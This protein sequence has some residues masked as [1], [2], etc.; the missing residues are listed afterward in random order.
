MAADRFCYVIVK[1]CRF[2]TAERAGGF[3]VAGS[4][5]GAGLEDQALAL[6][7][8][9]RSG[10]THQLLPKLAAYVASPG[11]TAGGSG[12]VPLFVCGVSYRAQGLA[13]LALSEY[14]RSRGSAQPDLD[15][16]A[17]A[18]GLQILEVRRAKT[19]ASDGL[20]YHIYYSRVTVALW[21]SNK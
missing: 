7:L 17:A 9:L 14:D 4:A 20:A 8:L 12:R 15:V 5:S 21:S 16:S 1:Y 10:A 3:A 18:N 2:V 6:L 11:V 13:V 19:C